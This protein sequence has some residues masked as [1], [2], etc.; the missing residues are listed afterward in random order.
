[1]FSLPLSSPR[2]DCAVTGLPLM[3]RILSP[4]EICWH[5]SVGP[6][7]GRGVRGR[8]EDE[9]RGN[10]KKMGMGMGMGRKGS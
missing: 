3:A 10:E 1:M 8:F 4:T 2:T 6:W 9:G 5:L 7:G